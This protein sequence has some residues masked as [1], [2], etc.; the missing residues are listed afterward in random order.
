MLRDHLLPRLAT[1]LWMVVSL[2]FS[3][4]AAA[5]CVCP[6]TADQVTMAQKMA[7]GEPCDGMDTA[8][9]APCHSQGAVVS[10]A[11]DV[12]KAASPWCPAIVQVLV[13]PPVLDRDD[14]AA[15]TV[16]ATVPVRP[17]PDPIFLATLRLRV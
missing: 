13:V 7:S 12:V 17:P 8:Q 11:F 6:A 2:L 3:Q 15:L 5:T 4:L 1:T 10:P 14:A 16:A 9:P